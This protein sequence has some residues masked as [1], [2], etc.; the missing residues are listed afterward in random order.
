M[1]QAQ[2]RFPPEA[3]PEGMALARLLALL[4]E[5][6]MTQLPQNSN[7]WER[8]GADAK[9]PASGEQIERDPASQPDAARAE[10][11]EKPAPGSG[12]APG[13]DGSSTD[14]TGTT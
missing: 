8:A 3:M 1:A 2:P 11:E 6:A 12:E 4:Q 9:A 7:A 10:G 13:G 5:I 14:Q